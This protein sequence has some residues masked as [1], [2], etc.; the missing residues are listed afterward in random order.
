PPVEA[1]S[2]PAPT[3]TQA[4]PPMPDPVTASPEAVDVGEP[5]AVPD[6]PSGGWDWEWPSLP[7]P[8]FVTAAGFAVL[9]GTALF[10]Q[11]LHRAGVLR[12]HRGGRQGGSAGDAGRV[13][14]ATRAL[15]AAL[16]DYGFADSAPLLVL[17]TGRGL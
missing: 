11:R 17:E 2:P 14:L 12:L 3:P 13:A 8:V 15:Q 7:R 5:E 4:P 1:A 9:G 6:N 16:T 10:V